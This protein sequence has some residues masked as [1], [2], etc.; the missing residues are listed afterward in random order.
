MAA[1]LREVDFRG[2]FFIAEHPVRDVCGSTAAPIAFHDKHTP[3]ALQPDSRSWCSI[4][5]R[6]LASICPSLLRQNQHRIRSLSAN[7]S[8]VLWLPDCGSPDAQRALSLYLFHNTEPAT[9][10]PPTN[11]AP[12]PYLVN[13]LRELI[14]DQRSSQTLARREPAVYLTPVHRKAMQKRL[15]PRSDCSG[16]TS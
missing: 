6:S 4:A 11:K 14:G 3:L 2:F 15:L 1:Q 13:N 7:I 12:V 9:A 8:G 16:S 5:A 10:P